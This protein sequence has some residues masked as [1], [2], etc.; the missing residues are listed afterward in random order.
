MDHR[1]FPDPE[2]LA[3]IVARA[4]G[5]DAIAKDALFTSLYSELHRMAEAHLRRNGGQ[6]TLG[7][8]TLL[9]EAYVQINRNHAI[10][11][12]D[13]LR[14]LKY[15][16]KA[17]RG[18]VIDY[19]RSRKSQKRGGDVTFMTLDEA[20]NQIPADAA[21]LE[22]IGEA[23]DALAAVDPSLT[24]LVDLRFFCGFSFAEI[25]AIRGSSERT[26]QREWGKARVLLHRALSGDPAAPAAD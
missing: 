3:D 19:V 4:E 1:S 14:F 24:E 12:P 23:L 2:S 10:A 13:R 18:L 21:T 22:R 17:M 9:H 7:T 5:G 20:E 26:E 11:F 16:S 8:T 25:A 15:A 6:L